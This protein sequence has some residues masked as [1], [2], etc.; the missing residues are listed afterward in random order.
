MSIAA[1]LS[2]KAERISLPDGWHWLRLGEV[3]EF[4]YGSG[5]PAQS[6]QKGAVPVY[7]SNGIVGYHNEALTQGTTIIIGRKGSI[8]EVHLSSVPCY[9]IDTTYFIEQRKTD[10][11]LTWLAFWL[12]ALN[13][14]ELNKAAAV[15]GLN[16]EDVYAIKIP[17]PPFHEQKRIAAILNEQITAVEQART[18]AE[19]QLK[20]AKDLPAAYLREVFDSSE[21][22]QWEKLTLGNILKVRSGNFLPAK[23]MNPIGTYPVYGGNGINGFHDEFMFEEPKIVIGRVGAL[24]G[25]IH[26][27]EPHA[28]ITDNALYVSEKLLS[29]DDEF[30]ATCLRFLNLNEHSNSMAQ[31][32]VTGQIIYPL[33]IALPSMNLQQQISKTLKQ[34]STA[35]VRISEALQ[36]Q[37]DSINKLPAALLRQAFTG[38]L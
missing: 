35:T 26:I 9:P 6:R 4:T 8:G 1:S 13:L 24:C 33:E 21:A 3:C 14:R 29:F 36:N 12:Q 31:P 17:Y 22:Q 34:Q 16:R 38:K 32:L 30:V 25:C 20:A 10:A 7:G 18:A 5:L 37:L 28:W 27:T 11:D 2:D 15:P 19:A 23:S